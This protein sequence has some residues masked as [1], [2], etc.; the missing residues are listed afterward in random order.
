MGLYRVYG[1]YG[2]PGGPAQYEEQLIEAESPEV[3]K[4]QFI[5]DTM[6][7]KP[8]TWSRMGRRNVFVEELN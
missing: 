4:E 7:M 8:A 5:L 1:D 2:P 6:L 3:A